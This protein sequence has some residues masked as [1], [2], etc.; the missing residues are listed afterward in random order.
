MNGGTKGGIEVSSME[1]QRGYPAFRDAEER[2]RSGEVDFG[3]HW[4][5]LREGEPL[6]WPTWRISWIWATGELYAVELIPETD[7]P[8]RRYIVLGRFR[9]QEE[10][11]RFME[12][13]AEKP[14]RIG[15][16]VNAPYVAEVRQGS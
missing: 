8:N 12:G 10:V 11:E 1:I 6:L 2:R 3:S 15:I 5:E 13:W 4:Y 16:L 9:R 7:N 14:R